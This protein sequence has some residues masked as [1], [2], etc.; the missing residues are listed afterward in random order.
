M[1]NPHTWQPHDASPWFSC[2][3]KPTACSMEKGNPTVLL[4]WIQH[5]A[6]TLQTLP[7]CLARKTSSSH[8]RW[9]P[10]GPMNPAARGAA[11]RRTNLW[12]RLGVCQHL[13]P[14]KLLTNG[15]THTHTLLPTGIIHRTKRP[16][17]TW[18]ES[19]SEPGD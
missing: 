6:I 17:W 19:S 13:E 2:A 18:H 3:G 8:H 15:N 14:K 9:N 7:I 1:P 11:G 16:R 12:V 10:L 5:S 4:K